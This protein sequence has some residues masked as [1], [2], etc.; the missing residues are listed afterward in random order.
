MSGLFERRA[1]RLLPQRAASAVALLTALALG[2]G[3]CTAGPSSS[4]QDQAVPLSDGAK[5]TVTF[6]GTSDLAAKVEPREVTQEMTEALPTPAARISNLAEFTMARGDFPD[7]GAQISFT[8]ETPPPSGTFSLIVH[9]N[10]KE[11]SWEPVKTEQSEDLLTLTATVEHFSGYS[12]MDLGKDLWDSVTGGGLDSVDKVINGTGQWLGVQ[13]APPECGPTNKPE[14]A[15]VF[16][17]RSITNIVTSCAAGSSEHV[18]RLKVKVTVNRSY[19]GFFTTS[20]AAVRSNQDGLEQYAS[21]AEVD[22]TIHDKGYLDWKAIGA[23]MVNSPLLNLGEEVKGKDVYPAMPFATYE[24]EFT[25]QDV[26]AAWPEIE[27]DGQRLIVFDTAPWL[28]LTGLAGAIVDAAVV[29]DGNKLSQQQKLSHLALFMQINDCA[30]M[31]LAEPTEWHDPEK[32]LVEQIPTGDQLWSM[33]NCAGALTSKTLQ[34]GTLKYAGLSYLMGDDPT[35]FGKAFNEASIKVFKFVAA[36]EIGATLGTAINDVTSLTLRDKSIHFKP[37]KLSKK[38][39]ASE[40]PNM[41]KEAGAQP[42]KLYTTPDG[43]YQFRHPAGW[44]VVPGESHPAGSGQNLKV[45]NEAGQT[46]ATFLT[47][48]ESHF[49]QSTSIDKF[50]LDHRDVQGLAEQKDATANGFAFQAS[51]YQGIWQGHLGVSSF[52]DKDASRSWAR[53]FD[54][55]GGKTG[56]F[57][58]SIRHDAVLPG[59]DPGLAGME[60]LKAYMESA[61]YKQIR[62]MMESLKD[63]S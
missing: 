50:E 42:W 61:E 14:W 10:E 6:P 47:G 7:T 18:D 11:E 45:V 20:A 55:P 48:L 49:D 3:G 58:H 13:V 28:A 21:D 26:M 5:V 56:S 29:V 53:G 33:L 8:R 38:E 32:S 39:A 36:V 54:T 52:L 30:K 15:E 57:G 23:E 2:L 43:K 41:E 34:E 35:K 16:G 4:R 19:A 40:L 44:N 51:S 12:I 1:L 37:G 31:N 17:Q 63:A 22:Q 59:V 25:E 27:K 62:D 24:F 60:R 9:W 46:M